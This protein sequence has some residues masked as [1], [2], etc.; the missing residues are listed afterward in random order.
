MLAQRVTQAERYARKALEKKV[1]AHTISIVVVLVIYRLRRIIK[2]RIASIRDVSL[3]TTIMVTDV[4]L[5]IISSLTLVIKLLLGRV[6]KRVVRRLRGGIVG[7][8]TF[9]ASIA[10]G[11]SQMMTML[12]V[13][14][15]GELRLD[16]RVGA[17]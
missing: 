6:H 7:V 10:R 2:G 3:P 15:T 9:W 14:V 8:R 4:R 13:V 1:M 16:W 11:H 5:C 17:V 12:D